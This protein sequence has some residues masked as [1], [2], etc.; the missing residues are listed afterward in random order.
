MPGSGQRLSLVR[1]I[2][3]SFKKINEKRNKFSTQLGFIVLSSSSGLQMIPDRKW[4][5]TGNDPDIA[6]QLIPAKNK[7]LNNMDLYQRKVKKNI[8]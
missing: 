6:P 4:S 2:V 3:V 5:S 7:E 8:N 1:I